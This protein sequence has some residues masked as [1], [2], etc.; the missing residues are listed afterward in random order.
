MIHFNKICQIFI[1][2]NSSCSYIIRGSKLHVHVYYYSGVTP[3]EGAGAIAPNMFFHFWSG[4][5][6]RVPPPPPPPSFFLSDFFRTG[7]ALSQD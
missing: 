7:S 5:C 1:H 2:L 6:D 3:G 4:K